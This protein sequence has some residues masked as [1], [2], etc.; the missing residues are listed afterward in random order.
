[1]L[2]EI[3]SEV[4]TNDT[5]LY[6]VF[7]YLI[8][9]IANCFFVQTTRRES[10]IKV[11]IPACAWYKDISNKSKCQIR[12]FLF[13]FAN[14]PWLLPIVY[15]KYTYTFVAPLEHLIAAC[16]G[17][18]HKQQNQQRLGAFVTRGNHFLW[19]LWILIPSLTYILRRCIAQRELQ[20]L[21]Y[22]VYVPYLHK[23]EGSF[24]RHYDS[25]LQQMYHVQ[26]K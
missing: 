4:S 9:D 1:M 7:L 3:Y 12:V 22:F 25:W 10:H 2:S 26:L 21:W 13:S 14:I 15:M 5:W 11:R 24:I 16:V 18:V 17:S 19:L 6:I 8:S 20:L 23:N